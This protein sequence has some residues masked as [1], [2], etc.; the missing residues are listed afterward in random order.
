MLLFGRQHCFVPVVS[1]DDTAVVSVRSAVAL[2]AV[3]FARAVLMR[4]RN[5]FVRHDCWY[6]KKGFLLTEYSLPG[7]EASTDHNLCSRL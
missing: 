6:E 3:D 7:R 4:V 2:F 1:D 5:Q